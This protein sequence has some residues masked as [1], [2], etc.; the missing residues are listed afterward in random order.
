MGNRFY[1]DEVNFTT[2]VGINELTKSIGFN[3]YPNPTLDIFNLQF[4]LSNSA[5]IKYQIQSITGSTFIEESEQL[6]LEGEYKIILNK[7]KSL[8]KGIYFLNL[9]INGIK[10]SRKLVVN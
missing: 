10:M 1:L 9:E 7:N 5:K 2:P 8:A 4:T 3:V 6:Y